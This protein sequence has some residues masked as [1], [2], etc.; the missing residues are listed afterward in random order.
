MPDRSA[1]RRY[2]VT[3]ALPYAN[4]PL[5]L[6]HL[7]G[8]YLPA[9]LFCRYL[10]LRGRDVVYVCGSDEHGVPILLRAR[11]EGVEPQD[12]VDRYHAQIE[13]AFERFGMSFDIYSRTTSATHRATSQDFFRTLHDA[14]VFTERTEEQLYDPEA[15]LFLADRFVRG[16]C[17]IC[18]YEDAYGDQCENCGSSLSPKDLINP[19]SVLTDA[20]PE[21]RET[22][23]WYLPLGDLQ[24]RLEAWIA[25]HPDWKPNVRGQVGSWFAAGLADRAMTRDLPW[26]IPVP[27]EGAEGKVLYVWFDA[28]IGYLSATKEWA[29]RQGDPDAWRRYWQDEGAGEPPTDLIHF[30]GKD[31]IVFHALIFPALL[32]AYNDAAPS[33]RFVLPA[34]VPANEF[35]NLEGRKLSTSRGWAVWLH[36]ALGDLDGFAGGPDLLRYALAATL[37]ETKDADFTWADFQNRVNGE[38]GDALGNFV[39]R[40]LTFAHR[41]AGGQVPPLT[42]PTDADRAVLDALAAYPER[43]GAAYEGFRTREAVQATLD[44]ARLGN[45]YF[46]DTEPWKTR[47]SDPRAMRNTLHVCLQLCASLSILMDPALPFSAARLRTMLGLSN[48]RPSAPGGTP[49]TIGWDAAGLALLTEGHALGEAEILFEKIEDAFV[50]AQRA[51]LEARAAE[52]ERAASGEPPYEPAKDTVQFDDFARLDFRVGRVTVAEAH[53]NADKLLRVEVDLG[54]ETR[55]VLAGVAEH[56]R[57]EDLLGKQ[58]V[59]VANLAPRTM[60]GLESQGML[61]MA[62]DRDG[63]LTPVLASGG[64]PGAV[65]R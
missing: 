24:P 42:E 9:D 45:K 59:V 10:R 15:G 60:R 58:V 8:A 6:G 43:I 56:M 51:K 49:G 40:T 5:H 7:A 39:N 55:Q 44:L 29:A 48:V 1:T 20:V 62:E 26:G 33:P 2:L 36:D 61:L 35:L 57:P 28:P 19:R 18:G 27:V 22:T 14:G 31:N 34:N 25:E 4:G 17:P 53:P 41:F 21:L 16:T 23:H 54:A 52:A 3:S 37:P 65:V 12:I 13:A 64:E 46:N 11:E 63:R 50:E 32:M 47:D 38:L 30:I